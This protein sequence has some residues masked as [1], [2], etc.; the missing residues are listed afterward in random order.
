MLST[1]FAGPRRIVN[2]FDVTPT[3][4]VYEGGDLA[5][6]ASGTY[7]L[8]KG[9]TSVHTDAVTVV[10]D[11]AQVTIPAATLS[12]LANDVDYREVWELNIG[13]VEHSMRR[14]VYLVKAD[15]YPVVTDLDLERLVSNLDALR[16]ST[17]D[18][19]EPYREEAWEQLN[20]L[21]LG[22]GDYPQLI[23]NS[24]AFRTPHLYLTMMLIAMDFAT[25]E[26][27]NG[28]WTRAVERYEKKWTEAFDKVQLE[29]DTDEDGAPD[30]VK[31]GTPVYFLTGVPRGM[32]IV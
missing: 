16:P 14:D 21:L 10:S 31:S 30:E 13:G 23:T 32:E 9:T 5:T 8:Y 20:G 4:P 29:Y 28:K 1:R 7:T 24:W 17:I 6:P 12:A 19:Y 2:G 25:E 27:G 11:I 15:L 26:A 3:F 18:S 22:L